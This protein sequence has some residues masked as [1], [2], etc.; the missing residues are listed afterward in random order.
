[1][2][3]HLRNRENNRTRRQSTGAHLR[4]VRRP[5]DAL[6]RALGWRAWA[7]VAAA[8]CPLDGRCAREVRIHPQFVW[9]GAEGREALM[10][11]TAGSLA[12][13]LE[14]GPALAVRHS[15]PR[16]VL[17]NRPQVTARYRRAIRPSPLNGPGCDRLSSASRPRLF[18]ALVTTKKPSVNIRNT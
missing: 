16:P 11:R 9:G 4:S 2:A 6:P 10:G 12:G 1:M 8:P 14:A 5:T 3:P 13:R 15:A 7:W 18:P 17:A